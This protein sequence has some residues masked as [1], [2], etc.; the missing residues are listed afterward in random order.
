MAPAARGARQD[1]KTGNP[2]EGTPPIRKRPEDEEECAA[3][4]KKKRRS[5]RKTLHYGSCLV[6]FAQQPRYVRAKCA[7]VQRLK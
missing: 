4:E 2:E 3:E 7:H 1:I 5:A 6:Y